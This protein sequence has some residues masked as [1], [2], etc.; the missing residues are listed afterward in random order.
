MPKYLFLLL[1]LFAPYFASSQVGSV[2]GSVVVLNVSEDELIVAADSLAIMEFGKPNYSYCK[3]TAFGNQIVFSGVNQIAYLNTG[4]T[5]PV[6]SWDGKE[7]LRQI[8]KSE[9][10][11]EAGDGRIMAIAS[12][13]AIAIVDKLQGNYLWHRE[14]VVKTAAMG[15]GV[16][17]GG[18]FAEAIGGKIYLRVAIVTF[19][20]NSLTPL[21]SMVG[22]IGNCWPCGQ[23]DGTVCVGGQIHTVEEF[24]TKSTE[25][26][27]GVEGKLTYLDGLMGLGWD[28]HSL[29]ALRL[30]DLTTA[31]DPSGTVGGS[32]DVLELNRNGRIHWLAIDSKHNEHR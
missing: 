9:P 15:K 1:G 21:D 22:T 27:K 12:K 4:L 26:A 30:A 23:E 17:V 11:H 2:H 19:N 24:C 29:L 5:D 8:I 31:Y 16:L 3:I 14:E 6:A 13:W 20:R 7:I 32:I 28:S 25:R 10:G 18:I